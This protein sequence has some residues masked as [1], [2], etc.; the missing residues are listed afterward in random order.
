[1][2]MTEHWKTES[3]MKI[4]LNDIQIYARH[5]VL[6]QEKTLGAW[7]RVS[8]EGTVMETEAARSDRLSDTV[9]YAD[10]AQVVSEE[11]SVPSQLLEHVCGRIGRRLLHDF[12]ALVNVSIRLI[13]QNPPITGLQCNGAGVELTLTRES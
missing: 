10:I 8:V 3:A 9:S 6:P 2:K 1:M 12:P 4:L 13:K 11:M 7:F 5:G